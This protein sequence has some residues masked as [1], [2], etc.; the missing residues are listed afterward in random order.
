MDDEHES[1]KKV[2]RVFKMRKLA[3]ILLYAS[4]GI[5]FF[6]YVTFKDS[7]LVFGITTI[8]IGLIFFIAFFMI[9]IIF[10]KCPFCGEHFEIRHSKNDSMTHCPFCGGELRQDI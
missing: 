7:M 10:W 4:L 2:N 3:L 1:C 5:F 9:S 8:V 6:G